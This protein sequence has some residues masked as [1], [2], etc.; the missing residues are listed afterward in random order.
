MKDKK[1]RKALIDSGIIFGITGEEEVYFPYS[2]SKYDNVAM[3][4]YDAIRISTETKDNISGIIETLNELMDYIG[5]E[6]VV[7]E[8]T[9]VI[10]KKGAKR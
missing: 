6:R 9:H 7:R 1:L 3:R 8:R 4:A 2:D 5:V 10:V